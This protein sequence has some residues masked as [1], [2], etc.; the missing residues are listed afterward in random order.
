VVKTK[1]DAVSVYGRLGWVRFQNVRSRA[2]SHNSLWAKQF[3]VDCHFGNWVRFRENDSTLVVSWFWFLSSRS[4]GNW[5]RFREK[6]LQRCWSLVMVFGSWR[7]SA[8]GFVFAKSLGRCWS[9]QVG[10]R[11]IRPRL[12]AEKTAKARMIHTLGTQVRFAKTLDCCWSLVLSTLSFIDSRERPDGRR[13]AKAQ[14]PMW[15]MTYEMEGSKS[16]PEKAWSAGNRKRRGQRN[17]WG[18]EVGIFDQQ[19]FGDRGIVGLLIGWD[20]RETSHSGGQR[21]AIQLQ[22]GG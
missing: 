20:K 11:Q 2:I 18:M 8:I 3:D 15:N 12:K 19:T 1:S 7:H 14:R 9:L 10:G 4:L 17:E 13:T 21:P 5:L 6:R 16:K 22:P